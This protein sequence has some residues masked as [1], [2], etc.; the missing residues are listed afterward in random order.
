MWISVCANYINDKH[1]ALVKQSLPLS[2]SAKDASVFYTR[3]FWG[4]GFA[5]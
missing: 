3:R 2:D 4:L 5:V 1:C